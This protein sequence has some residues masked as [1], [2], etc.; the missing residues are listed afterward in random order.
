VLAGAGVLATLLRWRRVADVK[1]ATSATG[2]TLLVGWFLVGNMAE[3]H[4]VLAV[5]PSLLLA[6]CLNRKRIA[7][8]VAAPAFLLAFFP[9]GILP[10]ALLG[11][12]GDSPEALQLRY[13][14][15]EILVLAASM[16]IVVA[17]K[18]DTRRPLPLTPAGARSSAG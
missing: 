9:R 16:A 2:V 8:L 10:V 12:A 3:S 5:L 7:V 17:A 15:L 13:V 14:A 6:V 1:G 18:R 11:G 4:W